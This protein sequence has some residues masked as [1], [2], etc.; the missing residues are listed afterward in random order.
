MPKNDQPY[1]VK[2]ISDLAKSLAA[3]MV[4]KEAVPS[5]LELLNMLARAAGF[6]NYQHFH[7]GDAD[8]MPVRVMTE[9]PLVDMKKIQKVARHF[10]AGG[11]L[12]RW[13]GKASERT[14]VLWVLWSRI[15]ARRVFDEKTIS[16]LLDSHHHFGDYA[17]LRREMFGRGM[18]TRQRDGSR[19]QRIEQ[20]MP[21]E[22]LALVRHL[23]S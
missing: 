5:H 3:Q 12:V 20:E 8:I 11:N 13:P 21:A 18:L 19:Y 23:G 22:A 15:P 14:L 1:C 4:K 2:D 6:R 10:D 9:A 7:A 16:E 17:L